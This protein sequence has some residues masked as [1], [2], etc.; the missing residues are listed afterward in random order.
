MVIQKF[1]QGLL[2]QLLQIL[3][4]IEFVHTNTGITPKYDRQ[5]PNIALATAKT[6]L[7]AKFESQH[8]NISCLCSSVWQN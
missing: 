6:V 4:Q 1:E 2:L 7:C 5:T 8:C 3:L